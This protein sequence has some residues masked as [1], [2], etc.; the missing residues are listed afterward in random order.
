MKVVDVVMLA[1]TATEEIFQMN[2]TAISSLRAAEPDIHF[3]V[4]LIESNAAFEGLGWEYD[5]ATQVIQPREKFNFNRFNNLGAALG[6]ADW[7]V[8]SNNDVV[9]EQGWCTAL[10][11]AHAQ[12]SRLQ[13]LCPVDPASQYTPSGTFSSQEV[14][15]IGHH[16]RVTFTGW[17]FMVQRSVLGLIGGFDERFDYYFADDDFTLQLRQ[18][19]I[20]NAAVMGAHVHHL[21]HVTSRSNALDISEKFKTDQ[22]RFHSK[23]GSQR[24]IAW[25]NRLT[26][27]VLRPLGMKVLIRQLYRHN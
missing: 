20:L 11:H 25:K 12:N 13:S 22:A 7:V 17:C 1:F 21:A 8:F 23:W 16:V 26:E 6:S 10:L 19:D 5:P 24:L 3:N 27:K 4:F 15:R 14:F 18:F 2:C 9:F